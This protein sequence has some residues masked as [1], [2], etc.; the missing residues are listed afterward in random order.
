MRNISFANLKQ[1]LKS[2]SVAVLFI[3]TQ[4][5]AVTVP[6]LNT[7]VAHAAPVCVN[8][9]AG[10][11][12]PSGDGQKDLTRLCVD[13]DGAPTTIATTWNWD[14]TTI[15]G[16][17][18]LDACNLFDTDNDGFANTAVCVTAGG[19]PIAIGA[20]TTYTCSDTKID[21]CA[22]PSSVIPTGSTT[23]DVTGVTNDPFVAGD[24][25]P[26]DTQGSCTI[27][28]VA[29][30][31]SAATLIDVC[32]YPSASPTSV[33]SDCVVARPS[34]GKLEVKKDLVPD[35]ST[36]HFNLQIDGSTKTTT[37]GD[38]TTGE[39]VVS[40]GNHSIGETAGANTTLNAY[41]SSISCKDQNGT[42]N[43][44]ASGSTTSLASVPVADGADIVCVIT[45]TVQQGSIT[46]IKSVVND[47]GG[48]ATANQFGLTIDGNSVDSGQAVTLNP[49]S[50]TINEAGLAGYSFVSITGTGCPAQ[51]GGTVTLASN[52][53][54]VCTITN[55]DDAPTLTVTK[56]VINDDGGTLF[57]IDFD[58][59]VNNSP[60]NDPRKGGGDVSDNSVTHLYE[61]AEAGV[62]YTVSESSDNATQ[63]E[64]T[65]LVCMDTDTN[66]TVPHPVTLALGQSVD[67][68]ITNNDIAPTL[69]LIKTLVRDNGSL[70]SAEDWLLTAQEDG[71]API[72]NETGTS[73]D[74]GVTAETNVVDA[75]AGIAYVLSESGPSGYTASAWNCTGGSLFGS[76]LTLE[77][78]QN[79][80]C[81]ITN[82]DNTP[83]LTIEK[84]VVNDHGGDAVVGDFGI[85]LNNG[86]LGFGP[87]TTN[88]ST[89]T[90][91]AAPTVLANTDYTLSEEDLAGYAE[92]TWNCT[93]GTIGQGLS[94]T[95]NLNVDED[96]TCTVTNDDI[97]PVLTLKKEV[98]STND[99]WQPSDWTL[100]ATPSE[101]TVLSGN[102]E[103]GFEDKEALA[104]ITYTLSESNEGDFDASEWECTSSAGTF[105]HPNG[106]QNE[107]R[108]SEGAD[109]T[110][111]I[112]NTERGK[113]TIV[114]DAQPDSDQA[115]TFTGNLTGDNEPNFT[116]TDD[117]GET[118][119]ERRIFNSMPA[120]TYTVTEP[121]DVKGWELTDITCTG[122]SDTETHQRNAVIKLQPGEDVTCIFTN[123]KNADVVVHK[124]NDLNRSGT[125]DEN[126]PTLSNWEFT[127]TCEANNFVLF[128]AVQAQN[129]E[130]C[131]DVTQVTDEDGTT[132]FTDVLP[133]E[134][135]NHT[136]FETIPENSNWN[137]SNI[138]CGERVNGLDGDVYYFHNSIQAGETI[139]CYVGNYQDTG[140]IT[141][142]KVV[143]P[144][145]DEGKFNLNIN[146][147]TY[148][149]D[150]GDGGTTGQIELVTGDV[151]VSET[152][153]TNTN[154]ADYESSYNCVT[155]GGGTIASGTGTNID[156][157]LAKNQNIVCTFTN[158]KGEILGAVAPVLVNTGSN[159]LLTSVASF[160]LV[161]T[162]VG[163]T[164]VTRRRSPNIV[165][166]EL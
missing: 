135:Y 114:K 102:G 118:G 144:S 91:T 129:N 166:T 99:S 79:V 125:M 29:V 74:G 134:N 143:T 146:G 108:M 112:T 98:V 28:L 110:C 116:L 88:G 82:D 120:G 159:I 57:G 133:G 141:V 113:I 104:H 42:G 84:K 4:V 45:N 68:T 92:G 27:S 101:G 37:D 157:T 106:D 93:D 111:V 73:N 33:P 71:E 43:V 90:Y 75:S 161:G 65:G 147:T 58:L 54:I 47:D 81:T 155:V 77:L 62:E 34:A 107:I 2:G 69:Q 31:G 128:I 20:V 127:L 122:G 109:V 9:T 132:T 96:V 154:L 80:I 83:T 97:A 52:Q 11:N 72:I 103:D 36:K 40:A 145:T 123:V 13:Y 63:Y 16:G 22:S 117:A 140:T 49:G 78:G 1:R 53:D 160:M 46:L 76:N 150:I 23:C 89:T 158:N 153:G 105:S 50:Y 18:T 126:E 66:Q 17:N 162:V 12:D 64:N 32:S 139:H 165:A 14:E 124:Y 6:F 156:L 70:A 142:N 136:L 8:D 19:S 59:L 25:Y 56:H 10:A 21:R 119:N 39:I 151:T 24:N 60:V 138:D 121:S 100:T 163:L 131:T 38:G 15:P 44:V 149:T 67:C 85:T 51:L 48:Q 148:A 30:G 26:G 35:D 152:A 164:L 3:A 5:G 87:G 55:D 7:Q 115:F 137:L 41:T 61:G 86:A 95:V 130:N 94:V